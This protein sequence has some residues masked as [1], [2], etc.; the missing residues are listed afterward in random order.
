MLI[1]DKLSTIAVPFPEVTNPV[2]TE[3]MKRQGY[4]PLRMFKMAEDFFVSLG[5]EPMADMFWKES[6]IEKPLGRKVQCGG[7]AF[8]MWDKE[9]QDYR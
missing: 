9:K 6:M 2:V 8:D 4:T 1:P 3:E 7:G 5:M